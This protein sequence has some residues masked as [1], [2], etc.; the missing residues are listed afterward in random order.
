MGVVT[1]NLRID[2]DLYRQNRLL[3]VEEGMS[4][5]QYVNEVLEE[6]VVEKRFGRRKP[7][8][9]KKDF[10]EAMEELISD[11]H[12]NEPMGLSEEDRVIYESA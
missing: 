1:T 4:F 2:E 5:N 12:P 7:G 8:A 10:Y 6:K 9:K 11:P 3:A